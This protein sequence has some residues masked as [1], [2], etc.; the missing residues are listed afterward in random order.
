[1]INPKNLDKAI[2]ELKTT[3]AYS[4]QWGCDPQQIP[5]NLHG[6]LQFLL[7]LQSNINNKEEVENKTEN[8]QEN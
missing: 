5:Y 7:N 3:I 6:V 8:K 1:M 2:S 4:S